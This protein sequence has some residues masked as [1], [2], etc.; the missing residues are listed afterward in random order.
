[1]SF[2]VGV[3]DIAIIFVTIGAAI[4]LIIFNIKIDK[5]LE[6]KEC[7]NTKIGHYNRIASFLGASIFG[8]FL[9]ILALLPICKTEV[10]SQRWKFLLYAGVLF[11]IAIIIIAL[12]ISIYIKTPQNC[13]EIKNWAWGIIGIGVGQLILTWIYVRLVQGYGSS[14]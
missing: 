4:G 13:K 7:G 6:K 11:V 8:S 12:G 10:S 3:Y 2:P 14:A 1:M 5:I 9:T